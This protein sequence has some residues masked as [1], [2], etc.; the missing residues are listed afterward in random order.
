MFFVTGSL[1]AKSFERRA[2]HQVLRDRFR[3]LLLPLWIFALVAWAAMGVA[4]HRTSTSVPWHRLP[5]WL[6]PLGD[7]HGSDWEAGW[8]SSPLWYIRAVVWLMIA[9]PALH[10]AVRRNRRVAFGVPIALVFALDVIDRHPT[11]TLGAAPR[12]VWQVGDFALYAIFLMAGFLQRAGTFAAIGARRW[13]S[14]ALL[15]GGFAVAWRVTQPVPLGVVNNSHPLHLLVGAA[16][17]ALA[18]AAQ[19]L[20]AAAVA[21]RRV[22]GA[23][24]FVA[25]RAY[26]IYLW[27]TTAIIIALNV[28]DDRRY[29]YGLRSVSLAVFVA[30]GVAVAVA[31][32]GWLEDVAAGRPAR[33]WPTQP[34]TAGRRRSFARALAAVVVLLTATVPIALPPAATMAAT[35][36]RPPTPSQQP[37]RPTFSMSTV[38][39]TAAVPMVTGPAT[40]PPRDTKV[41]QAT[42]VLPELVE[43]DAI[44]TALNDELTRWATVNVVPGAVVG[45]A[46]GY[47]VLWTGATGVRLR[48]GAPVAVT[49]YLDIMSITKLF[50][51]ALIYRLVDA[52][53]IDLDAPLPPL[54][55]V[56]GLQLDR[57]ITPRQLLAHRSGLVNYRETPQYIANPAS[58][59]TPGKALLATASQPLN[60]E[61][62]SGYAYSSSNYLALGFLLEQ[63]TGESYD[64]LL[65]EQ[66]LEPLNLRHTSHRAAEPGEPAHATAGVITTIVDLLTAGTAILRDHFGMSDT[67]HGQMIRIDPMTGAGAGSFGFCPCGLDSQGDAHFSAVGN[68]GGTT[69]L[70][71]VPTA[72]LTMVMD[73][74][75]WLWFEGRLDAVMNELL[76][77][78][79][80]TA[81]L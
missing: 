6:L 9:S 46:R 34:I 15:L 24:R 7:P 76:A 78:G 27:H 1:L 8:M 17:L 65:Y 58:I 42:A 63:I 47:D 13:V 37:P 25:Q 62:G 31:L 4:A 57:R 53:Q 66:L 64:Q 69:L 33:V 59:D 5:A 45:I 67:A 55:A 77:L 56:S 16:W 48:D 71:Y 21:R 11:W 43:R 74:T 68:F 81:G 19:P 32:F 51:A 50:T 23:I 36:N 79:A 75:D 12:L 29:P 2:W 18:M 44:A 10:W 60:F 38:P 49:D 35:S 70:I 39:L 28:V 3:R 61:P 20:L 54:R 41:D 30:S 26:T 80:M 40:E 73:V 22:G 72:G 14:L 52:S